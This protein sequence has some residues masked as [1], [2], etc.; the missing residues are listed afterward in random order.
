MIVMSS[1]KIVR[2][3]EIKDVKL[4][5]I[6]KMCLAKMPLYFKFVLLDFCFFIS[7]IIISLS[8]LM[9]VKDA[10]RLIPDTTNLT[11][12]I[13]TA[14]KIRD[15]EYRGTLARI[16]VMLWPWFLA[17]SWFA[18]RKY[19]LQLQTGAKIKW[20]KYAAIFTWKLLFYSVFWFIVLAGKNIFKIQIQGFIILISMIVFTYVGM[21]PSLI[22]ARENNF[23]K[24]LNLAFSRRILPK[25]ALSVLIFFIVLLGIAQL[26]I[27]VPNVVVAL[28]LTFIWIFGMLA[29]MKLYFAEFVTKALPNKK[30]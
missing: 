26:L 12:Y 18:F 27:I 14:S 22:Y 6:F 9:I 19:S 13:N 24:S 23:I 8:V 10:A 16:S 15:N 5:S 28:I 1:K 3:R 7:L 25:A 20:L 2:H 21:L 30:S 17:I 4:L 29:F 11:A